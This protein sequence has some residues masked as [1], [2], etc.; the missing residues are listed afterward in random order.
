VERGAARLAAAALRITFKSDRKA[1]LS[2][3]GGLRS[4]LAR[5]PAS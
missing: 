3:H 4:W 5:M 2:A 1:R